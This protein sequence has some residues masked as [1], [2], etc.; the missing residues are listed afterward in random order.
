MVHR[1]GQGNIPDQGSQLLCREVKPNN[2]QQSTEEH[3]R[4]VAVNTTPKALTTREIEEASAVDEE[5][6]GSKKGYCYRAVWKA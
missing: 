5:L 4:F 2:H 3:V 1:P 6:G